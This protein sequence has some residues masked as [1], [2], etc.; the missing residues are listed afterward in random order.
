MESTIDQVWATNLDNKESFDGWM[1]RI[2]S[3]QWVSL[4]DRMQEQDLTDK[5][6]LDFGCNRGVSLRVLYAHRPFAHGY[7][8]D[9]DT[10]A[11]RV[12]KAHQGALP[13]TYQVN[14]N[15]KHLAGAIDIAFSHEVI[16]LLKD[17]DQHA[18]EM[19]QALKTNGVYYVALGT[20]ADNPIWQQ[21]KESTA[22]MLGIEPQ[23]YTLYQIAEVFERQGFAVQARKFKFDDFFPVTTFKEESDE[24]SM[25]NALN[26]YSEYKVLFRFTK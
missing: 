13:L 26:Y 22:K 6:V 25:L 21:I 10:A 2:N 15:I 11:I 5:V 14:D 19:F 24:I 23:D 8:V 16:Y 4:I 20:H 1:E 18:Q 3:Q 9:L 17:L 12:A 7:G